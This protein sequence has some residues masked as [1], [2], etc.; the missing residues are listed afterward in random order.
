MRPRPMKPMRAGE[1]MA[2]E[3]TGGLGIA[4][5]A[6]RGATS[7]A[8]A[9]KPVAAFSRALGV[10]H[11]A[12]GLYQQFVGDS[13]PRRIGAAASDADT[14]ADAQPVLR[15][16][17]DL[18][19]LCHYRLR[20]RDGIGP[21]MGYFHEYHELVA[22]DSGESVRLANPASDAL[23]DLLKQAVPCLVPQR[24]VDRLE[25]VDVE[26]EQCDLA[27]GACSPSDHLRQALAEKRPVRE[28]GQL[29]LPREPRDLLD[30]LRQQ[31]VR[32]RDSPE[33]N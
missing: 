12:I 2:R 29:I 1:T 15:K 31:T 3:F 25:A 16:H 14:C 19:D 5:R 24:V 27:P 30:F 10:V 7:A 11:G 32:T 4:S 8:V 26:Q 9:G 13:L 21:V 28:L 33:E 23:R 18:A 6:R 20:D 22:A 17:F